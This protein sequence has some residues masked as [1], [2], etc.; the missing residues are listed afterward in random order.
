V[1]YFVYNSKRTC[2]ACH[3][4]IHQK[5]HLIRYKS[6]KSLGKLGVSALRCHPVGAGGTKVYQYQHISRGNKLPVLRH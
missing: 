1:R 5:M 6:Y 2:S 4:H 3:R